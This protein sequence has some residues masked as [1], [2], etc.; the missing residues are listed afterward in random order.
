MGLFDFLFGNKTPSS[1]QVANDRIWISQQAK[2]NGLAKELAERP[3]VESVAVLLIGHFANTVE[4]LSGIAADYKGGVP[5]MA[6]LAEKVSPDIANKLNLNESDVIELIVAERHPLRSVDEA[7]LQ[8]AEE[9]PCRC[10]ISHHLALD[11]PLLLVFFGE[12][13]RGMLTNLGLS[14]DAAIESKMVSRRVQ[15]AQQKLE[16]TAVGNLEAESAEEWIKKNISSV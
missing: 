13:V 4:Q 15:Q 2:L 10:R 8:F 16:A 6:T 11:D 5:V 12:W 9:L 3:N 14:E 7:L 1:V